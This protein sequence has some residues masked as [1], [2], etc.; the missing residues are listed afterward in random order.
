MKTLLMTAMVVGI[1]INVANAA[2]LPE[3][4]P[5][6]VDATVENATPL[7]AATLDATTLD[8]TTLDAMARDAMARETPE[9]TP[10][11]LTI[12]KSPMSPARCT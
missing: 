12:L 8:A 1:V 5:D 9:A 11:S 4:K 3:A 7:S 2:P 6:E 10:P